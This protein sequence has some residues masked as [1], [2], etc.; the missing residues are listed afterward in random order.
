M[1][2][3]SEMNNSVLNSTT[4]SVELECFSPYMIITNGIWLDDDPLRYSLPLFL[5]QLLIITL[6]SRTLN[7]ILKP[8]GQPMV[9]AEILAGMLLGPSFVGKFFQGFQAHFFPP[10]SISILSSMGNCGLLCFVFMV[11]V[12]MDINV[13][14][15]MKKKVMAIGAISIVLP[16][17]ITLTAAYLFRG[18]FLEEKKNNAFYV[19]LALALSITTFP[20]L[21][22]VLRDLK[23]LNTEVGRVSILSSVVNDL[24]S[25]VLLALVAVLSGTMRADKGMDGLP[26]LY[27]LL[28]SLGF[29]IICVVL[30]RPVLKWLVDR[31]PEGEPMSDIDLGV[32]IMGV[33]V[34][35]YVTDF[36]GVHGVF[37]AFIYGLMFPYGTHGTALVERLETFVTGLILP[38]YFSAS[39]FRTDLSTMEHSDII[40]ILIFIFI[41]SSF[42]KVVTTTLASSY[43]GMPLS[44]G[45]SLG[46]LMNSPGLSEIILLNVARDKDIIAQETFAIVVVMSVLMTAL[47]MPLVSASYKPLKN[48]IEYK[49]RSLMSV[50]PN[51][52]L[53]MIAC[54]HSNNNAAS[55]I[56][57]LDM[58]NPTKR[59]PISVASLH[60]IELTGRE[61]AVLI[62]HNT[63][64]NSSMAGGF[65]M[66]NNEAQAK[67]VFTTFE[68]YEQHAGGISIQAHTAISPYS[69]MHDNICT[70]AEEKHSSIIILPFDKLQ[71][72]DDAANLS[73]RSVNQNV[74]DY[75]PCSVAILVDRGLTAEK[76]VGKASLFT[77][78]HVVLL[79][80]GG[81]DDREAL[82]YA[83][84]MAE[85]PAVTLTVMRF[86]PGEQ[87]AGEATSISP[88]L[89]SYG[90]TNEL[91]LHS[92]IIDIG[93]SE[94]DKNQISDEEYVSEFWVKNMGNES[95][96]YVEMV[97]N[98]SEE[99]VA[100]IRSI[101]CRCDLYIVGRS[102][103][104]S[105]LT[106]GL[107]EWMERPELGPIGDL[108]ASTDVGEG[109]SVLVVQQY[110]EK[111]T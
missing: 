64:S 30:V 85:H 70:L 90:D 99:T 96:E 93:N 80:F 76:V 29:F 101:D 39:G 18:Y 49:E 2:Q 74:L 105:P 40:A 73:I 83:W 36:I 6:T 15:Q 95:I 98:S 60:L 66:K 84:R 23:L 79:F 11:G 28:S 14:R 91:L 94:V 8:F 43:F 5:I 108:L 109:M 9:L 45:L 82:S 4:P 52:E 16:F 41:L 81:P 111:F 54:A 104:A 20:V 22:R 24:F 33:M 97:V 69:L 88:S 63:D 34:S 86:V 46:F 67:D 47:M 57:L 72:V 25:W 44:E 31:T 10:R 102:Q 55:L 100:I 35:A 1:A 106:A 32:V 110:N 56:G 71:T 38:I 3:A 92:S 68:T 103:G 12:E 59:S 37:G 42:A 62:S 87:V 27:I 77:K 19:Y 51:E 58:S 50:K 65:N 26:F 53:R 21:A 107:T 78:R 89:F 61:S 7:A 13:L 75:A 48:I 17:A